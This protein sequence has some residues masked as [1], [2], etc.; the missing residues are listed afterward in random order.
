MSQY[1]SIG[2]L[3]RET[4]RTY[5]RDYWRTSPTCVEVWVEKDAMTSILWEVCVKW[6]VPLFAVRGYSSLSALWS[7]AEHISSRAEYGQRTHIVYLG[8]HDPSG[9]NIPEVAQNRLNQFLPELGTDRH[10][11]E[12][13]SICLTEEQID[14]YGL[15]T[16]PPKKTDS[17]TRK[18][19]ITRCAEID[20]MPISVIREI[21]NAAVE[22]HVH[23]DVWR[24]N[25]SAEESERKILSMWADAA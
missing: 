6:G 23:Q 5:R 14:T 7:V 20:A 13:E 15:L 25:L 4:A 22:R 19:G 21:T 24:R 16:R 1:G 9:L 11:F 17:R 3:L 8:D 10:C 12:L 18:S 2:E